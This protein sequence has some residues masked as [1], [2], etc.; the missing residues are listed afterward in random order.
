V[1]L[2]ENEG[3]VWFA[4]QV[5]YWRAEHYANSNTDYLDAEG[6]HVE[7]I[8]VYADQLNQTVTVRCAADLSPLFPQ[9]F[10]PVRVVRTGVAKVRMR[11]WVPSTP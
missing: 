7:V 2:F 8:Y 10:P 6:I 9:V 3:Y 4:D 5:P 11:A 1:R